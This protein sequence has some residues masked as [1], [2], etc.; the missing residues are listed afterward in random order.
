MRVRVCLKTNVETCLIQHTRLLMIWC[1]HDGRPA[2]SLHL[3]QQHAFGCFIAL[4]QLRSEF[5]LDDVSKEALVTARTK[6]R[7]EHDGATINSKSVANDPLSAPRNLAVIENTYGVCRL[8]WTLAPK[9]QP[10]SECITGYQF[11][12]NGITSLPFKVISSSGLSTSAL[13]VELFVALKAD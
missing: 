13:F 5:E 2:E 7:E 6:T 4:D 10:H 11:L 12:H 8:K 3:L 1:V 9:V